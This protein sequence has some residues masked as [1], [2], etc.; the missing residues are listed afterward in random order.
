MLKN[1]QQRLSGVLPLRTTSSQSLP[2]VSGNFAP[3]KKGNFVYDKVLSVCQEV[4]R[5]N[6]NLCRKT[7]KN[8]LKCWK[9]PDCPTS[10]SCNFLHKSQNHARS[11]P[12]E[13]RQCKFSINTSFDQIRGP[14]DPHP[15]IQ[16]R[17][18]KSIKT[19]RN[20]T[21]RAEQATREAHAALSYVEQ[22]GAAPRSTML[23]DTL[24]KYGSNF[25]I[26]KGQLV[27]R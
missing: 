22:C 25:L 13:S 17:V 21:K 3:F 24:Y 19:R 16:K 27:K 18:L 11:I 20:R 7:E 4:I 2:W 14:E 10:R 15:S 5:A 23:H 26:E 8:H 1:C 9:Q 6:Q 12:L